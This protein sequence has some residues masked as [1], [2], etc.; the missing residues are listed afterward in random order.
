M[1]KPKHDGVTFEGVEYNS[2]WVKYGAQGGPLEGA[3]ASVESW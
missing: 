3:H 1:A 2:V